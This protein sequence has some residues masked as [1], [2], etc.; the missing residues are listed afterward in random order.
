MVAETGAV[1]PGDQCASF[2]AVV[3][4]WPVGADPSSRNPSRL[5][6]LRVPEWTRS[7]GTI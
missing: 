2:N 6:P 7:A 3:P 1:R 4:W 5:A